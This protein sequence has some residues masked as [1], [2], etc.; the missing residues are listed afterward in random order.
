MLAI[1]AADTP[2]VFK[3]PNP[4]SNAERVPQ[5]TKPG[6]KLGH[7]KHSSSKQSFGSNKEATKASFIIHSESA[8]G[9]N[10]LAV[11]TAE[12]EPEYSA[13]SDFVPLH[14]GMNEGTKNN[15]YDHLYAGTDP[16]VAR[17]IE[18]ETSNT[19]KL[20][21]LA[22][23]VSHVQTCFKVLDSPEDDPVIVV[24]DSDEDEKDEVHATENVKTKD[25]SVPTSSSPRSSQS[26]ELTNQV[27]ILQ[28]QKHKLLL[29]KSLKTEFSNILSAQDFSSSLPT[30][31]KDLPSKFNELKKVKGLKKQFHKLEIE[32]PGDLKEILT[33]L[34][35]FTKTVASLTSQVVEL[36]TLQW[37]LPAEF[38]SLP[39][40]VESVQAKLKTFDALLSLLLNVTKA[41]NKFA[42]VLDSA[43][44]KAGDQSVPSAG[45]ADTMPAEEEKNTNQATISQLFQRRAEKNA[46]KDMNKQQPKPTTPPATTIKSPIITATTT[47]MQTPLQNPQKGSSQPKGEHIKKDKG[48]K[49]VSLKDAEEVSTE[50][51]SDNE[52]THV[53]GSMVKSSKKKEFKK[54]DFVIESEEHVHLTEEH[55]SAPN[56]IKKEAKAEASRREGE[57]RKEDPIDLLGPGVMNKYY[58]DKLQ[59]KLLQLAKKGK[60]W[61]SYKQI[62]ERMNYPRRTEAELESAWIDLLSKHDPLD[63]L[64]DLENM[65]TKHADDIHDFFR[66]NKRLKSSIQYKD[67]PAGTVLNEPVLGPGLD[68][69]ARTFSSLLLAEID[70]RNINPLKQMRFIEQLRQ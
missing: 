41:L 63:R 59:E 26:Q 67:H 56:K 44:Y 27:F 18:E 28:S 53:P 48:K 43:S 16:S 2:V 6:A 68:D 23:L 15:S 66:A 42:Q 8:S 7:K 19:I 29:V 52:T 22:K 61:T 36:K 30:K 45:Q 46:E 25:T 38:L 70:M 4:Y 33:K 37:E 64:N 34:E 20:E 55:I 31:L 47:Q 5:G 58:N 51:D 65:K 3:A 57:M 35:D 32:L 12:A 14:Q 9:N 40:Q 21:D 62:Q 17:Q 10:A 50:N 69:H 54:F 24:D 60:R 1:Y 13:P 11:S 39:I 49:A